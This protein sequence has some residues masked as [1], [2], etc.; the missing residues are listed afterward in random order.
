M[1]NDDETLTILQNDL[2]SLTNCVGLS[3]II[4]SQFSIIGVYDG[5]PYF[6]MN[7][8]PTYVKQFLKKM[9]F[10]GQNVKS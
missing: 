7:V 3:L 9:A 5:L 10:R 2:H 8:G 6:N 1:L 4:V